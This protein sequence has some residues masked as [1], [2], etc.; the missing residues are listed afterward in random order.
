MHGYGPGCAEG[1]GLA[2]SP[3]CRAGSC[4]PLL[5]AST[6]GL[7]GSPCG[8]AWPRGAPGPPRGP[9]AGRGAG[10]QRTAAPQPA[11]GRCRRVA[12]S[13]GAGSGSPAT[14]SGG[15]GR[16]RGRSSG[17]SPATGSGGGRPR[18]TWP[19]RP[20]RGAPAAAVGGLMAGGPQQRGAWGERSEPLSRMWPRAE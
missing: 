8:R 3:G 12:E 6:R 13:S 20:P 10:L 5:A 9:A 15:C 4:A 7:A 17:P 1:A 19:A 11:P 2:V 14:P 16:W 18:P